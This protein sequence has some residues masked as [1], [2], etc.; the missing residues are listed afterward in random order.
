MKLKN[1]FFIA[2][3]II[4][5]SCASLPSASTTLTQEVID[6]ASDMHSLNKSLIQRIFTEKKK[7]VSFFIEKTYTPT[8]IKKYEALLPD[9]LN[10]KKELPNIIQGIVP[11]IMQKKDSLLTIIDNQE[12]KLM[13]QLD[14][15]YNEYSKAA[16][17][18]QNLVNSAVKVKTTEENVLKTVDKLTGN[19]INFQKIES[20]L[21][22]ILAKSSTFFSKLNTIEKTL[23]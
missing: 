12:Q 8:L 17:S 4:L 6:E 21:D 15:S 5:Y 11:V 10:Y 14:D 16:S 9:T 1:I 23:K 3:F 2:F 13:K 22:S 20:N 19:K 7:Q 18:L